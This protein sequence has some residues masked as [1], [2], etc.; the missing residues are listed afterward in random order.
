M[1]NRNTAVAY[2]QTVVTNDTAEGD[3][4]V[5]DGQDAQRGLHVPAAL[6]QDKTDGDGL[7]GLPSLIHHLL[8]CLHRVSSQWIP[9]NAAVGL[10]AGVHHFPFLNHGGGCR[11]LQG[12]ISYSF[13][14]R[15]RAGFVRIQDVILEF[16]LG[17]LAPKPILSHVVLHKAQF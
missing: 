11:Y 10:A 6:L 5:E 13:K 3:D 7:Q 8:L 9:L 1:T 14:C 15:N 2:L 16:V 4:S 12:T 17:I